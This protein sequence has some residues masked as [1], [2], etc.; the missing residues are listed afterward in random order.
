[1]WAV[2]INRPY[3]PSI[4]FFDDYEEALKE[5][6]LLKEEHEPEGSWD[7]KVFIAKIDKI[8]DIETNY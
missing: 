4:E 1:M 7:A 6:E 5:Y 8:A 2:G 3:Y